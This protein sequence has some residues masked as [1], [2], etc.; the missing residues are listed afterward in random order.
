MSVRV[1]DLK[2]QLA[3]ICI[4]SMSFINNWISQGVQNIN[5]GLIMKFWRSNFNM[6]VQNILLGTPNWVDGYGPVTY[7]NPATSF[8]ISGFVGGLEIVLFTA[9][10][11][12]D[13]PLSGY[14]YLNTSWNRPDG[15][16]MFRGLYNYALNLSIPAG[17]WSGYF[18]M[19]NTGAAPWEVATSGTYSARAWSTGLDPSTNYTNITFSNTPNV[20]RISGSSHQGYIWV[21]GLY[22]S[23]TNAGGGYDTYSGSG[24]GA[25]VHNI[26]GT[27][28]GGSGGPG[29]IWVDTNNDLCFINGYGSACKV[30]WKI[31][32]FASYFSN[33]ATSTV[34]AGTNNAGKIWMDNEYGQ[35]HIA[36]IGYDGYKYI[37]GAGDYPYSF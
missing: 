15:S 12:W 17:Y 37:C 16:V 27:A 25:W 34:Y 24:Y 1:E 19:I 32:Q 5:N 18:Q 3:L 7:Y 35:T 11:H 30:P 9:V 29:Y 28:I 14:T 10:W 26:L 13:G 31:K 4:I 23:I 2:Y 21:D 33:G 22:L 20:S 8:N 36:Y 6:P